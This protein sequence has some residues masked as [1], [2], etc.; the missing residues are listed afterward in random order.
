MPAVGLSCRPW[1]MK[2]C[3]RQ[4]FIFCLHVSQDCNMKRTQ[5]FDLSLESYVA[6][7]QVPGYSGLEE[8]TV[9]D[10]LSQ[11]ELQYHH[12]RPSI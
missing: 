5:S 4:A 3:D 2:L 6:M 8:R 11:P 12:R 7:A 10:R 1:A 9:A